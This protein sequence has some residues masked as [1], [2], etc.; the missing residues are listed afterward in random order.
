MTRVMIVVT[1]SPDAADAV[2][3]AIAQAGGGQVGKYTHCAFTSAGDGR[4]KAAED[5]APHVGQ[6]GVINREPE[7]R[8]ETFCPREKARAV[9]AAIRAAHP[10][11]EPVIYALPVI[12]EAEL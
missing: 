11:E 10:Y 6:A 8:I 12:D 5:A 7:I 2:L 1:V 3:D 9:M 4:F